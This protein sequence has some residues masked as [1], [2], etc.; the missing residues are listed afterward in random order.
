MARHLTKEAL[1]VLREDTK[2]QIAVADEL[3]LSIYSIPRLITDNSPK[4]TQYGVL[5][6]IAPKLGKQPKS[7]ITKNNCVKINNKSEIPN[8]AA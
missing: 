7:L 6:L 5:E 1:A 4:L 3:D 2:L 8:T